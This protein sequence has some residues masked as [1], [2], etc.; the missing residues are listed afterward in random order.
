[1]SHI[2]PA[3]GCRSRPKMARSRCQKLAASPC[4]AHETAVQR[5]NG[6]DA[7]ASSAPAPQSCCLI[8]R[9]TLTI[10]DLIPYSTPL[11]RAVKPLTP[12]VMKA[13][14]ACMAPTPRDLHLRREKGQALVRALHL[15]ELQ[16]AGAARA[17][18]LHEADQQLD[19][20]AHRLPEA[21]AAGISLTEIA[22][23]TNVSRPT[24]YELRSRYRNEERDVRFAVLQTI[25]GQGPI[26]RRGVAEHLARPHA[27]IDG[28]IDELLKSGKVSEDINADGPEPIMEVWVNERGFAE[29]EAWDFD[30]FGH[31]QDESA[32]G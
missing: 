26:D 13:T 5:R 4:D 28:V 27:E 29:I 16:A 17:L 22:R 1:M 11:S 30:D 6:N 25:L 14:V 32:S 23:V 18:A 7:V 19:R 21:L 9:R 15:S 10:T 24:L 3:Q 31:E 2:A 8:A 12:S 20:I